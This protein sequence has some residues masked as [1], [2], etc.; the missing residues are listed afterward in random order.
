MSEYTIKHKPMGAY[1]TNCFI[2]T[3]KDKDII[4]DPGVDATPWILKNTTNPIA[5]L[6]THGHFDH[7]WSNQ[8][9]K[10]KFGLKIYC[11]KDDVFMLEN[12]PFS[13]GTPPSKVDIL[14]NDEDEFE[15]DGFKFKFHHF[16]GHTP[17]CSAIEIGEHLFTGDFIFDGSIGRVDFPF[18]NPQ[19]MI[20][21][22]HKVLKWEKDYKIYPGHGNFSS[23]FKQ[24]DSLEAWI[25]YI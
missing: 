5:I 9:V 19:Q 20:N 11:P 1:Q 2:V 8:E 7:V 22:L 21:S 10:E 3:Y 18:S 14:V 17:G 23:L 24:K 6:N 12:D 13:Q 25:D 4:I 16:P 15:L